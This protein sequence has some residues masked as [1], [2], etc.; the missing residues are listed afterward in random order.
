MAPLAASPLRARQLMRCVPLP[1]I[2]LLPKP[3]IAAELCF[4]GR[5]CP[6]YSRPTMRFSEG[7][8]DPD[9]AV[10]FARLTNMT[11]SITTWVKQRLYKRNMASLAA[12]LAVVLALIWACLRFVRPALRR[13]AARWLERQA[14]AQGRRS[15]WRL[16]AL[17]EAARRRTRSGGVH[18]DQVIRRLLLGEGTHAGGHRPGGASDEEDELE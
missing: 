16:D 17:Q 14:E 12:A 7:V 4:L 1:Q 18:H 3:A 2:S 6:D 13:Q 9:D 10:A 5:F 15:R 8:R 11:G